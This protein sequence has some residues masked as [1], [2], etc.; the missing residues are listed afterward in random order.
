M[1]EH[2]NPARFTA[3]NKKLAEPAENNRSSVA[4]RILF[5]EDWRLVSPVG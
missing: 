4:N 1:T 2:P 5:G 3:I